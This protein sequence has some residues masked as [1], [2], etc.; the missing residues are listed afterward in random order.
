[1]CLLIL[2]SGRFIE[3]L[4]ERPDIRVTWKRFTQHDFVQQIAKGTLPIRVFKEYL[5]QDYL[6]LA[7][8]L[9]WILSL[10]DKIADSLCE[11]ERIGGL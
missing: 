6:Y 2:S 8:F 9:A 3:Y 10:T 1:M 7:S 5:I 4:L 11:D